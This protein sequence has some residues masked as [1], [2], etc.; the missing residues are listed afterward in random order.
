MKGAESLIL[1]PET[2][3]S[4]GSLDTTQIWLPYRIPRPTKVTGDLVSQVPTPR[5]NSSRGK[6]Y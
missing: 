3:R 1:A 2:A 4:N 6:S 5:E